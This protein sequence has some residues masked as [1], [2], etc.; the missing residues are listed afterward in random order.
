MKISL[1]RIHSPK[2]RATLVREWLRLLADR[3]VDPVRLENAL[4]SK[5]PSLRSL[6]SRTRNTWH[7][8]KGEYDFSHEVKEAMSGC[9][10]CKA[11][12]TQCPI[13][14][15]VPEFRSRF[16]QLYHTRYLRPLRDHLVATVETYAP[17]MAR[18]P[19]T[20]N[21]FINQPL[22]RKLSA[23]HIGMVDLPL[24]STPSLQQQMVG[25]RSANM[26]LEQLEMRVHDFADRVGL[27]VV[28]IAQ[29][30]YRVFPVGAKHRGK[31]RGRGFC[32]V[33]RCCADNKRHTGFSDNG[34][35]NARFLLP[36]IY[37]MLQWLLLL[38]SPVCQL[39]IIHI[40]QITG[41]FDFDSCLGYLIAG[42][43]QRGNQR[44]FL[45]RCRD[46]RERVLLVTV[47][48]TRLL[49]RA[50]DARPDVHTKA[51]AFR[52]G[53]AFGFYHANAS[54]L[55]LGIFHTDTSSAQKYGAVLSV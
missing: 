6:I 50:D 48:N 37:A 25:H 28:G 15:D 52:T 30:L 2:G 38:L 17:L 53:L 14:I 36:H 8:N 31:E 20:F 9:L 41:C 34:R 46:L 32:G 12:S 45:N 16:L 47:Q 5:R 35:R 13:K 7:A 10:A 39:V 27:P 21:F 26:T 49:D 54:L 33:N 40:E 42:N 24:L 55:T 51:G 18:A 43:N 1:N 23:K 11:C 29:L 19:K 3:G 22:V 44:I 4:A